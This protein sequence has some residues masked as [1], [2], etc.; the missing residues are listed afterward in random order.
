MSIHRGF[1]VSCLE[2]FGDVPMQRDVNCKAELTGW[3]DYY[4]LR[5]LPL[6]SPVGTSALKYTI[7]RGSQS[8]G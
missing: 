6:R 7:V 1:V 3:R 8:Q 2:D 4:E 5:E